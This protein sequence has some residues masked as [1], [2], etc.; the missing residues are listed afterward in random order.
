[1]Y[2]YL[3]ENS[4]YVV[5]QRPKSIYIKRAECPSKGSSKHSF[6]GTIAALDSATAPV[7]DGIHHGSSHVCLFDGS[8]NPSRIDGNGQEKWGHEQG[9]DIC[10]TKNVGGKMPCNKI[11]STTVFHVGDNGRISHLYKLDGEL[12]ELPMPGADVPLP[13]ASESDG[14]WKPL[15]IPFTFRSSGSFLHFCSPQYETA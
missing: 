12:P 3:K 4:V 6:V 7:E 8:R 2:H 9:T 1:M 13:G 14:G 10:G 5:D 11:Y 15:Q